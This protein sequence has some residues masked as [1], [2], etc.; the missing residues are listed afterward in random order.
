MIRFNP[1][2]PFQV[3]ATSRTQHLEREVGVSTLTGPLKSVQRARHSKSRKSSPISILT[4]S[5]KSVQLER[6]A[7]IG[8]K[9][10]VSILTG[11][12]KSVQP[13]SLRAAK[14]KKPK[15]QSSLPLSSQFN[16]SLLVS[17]DNG[18]MF[19]PSSTSEELMYQW[20]H[21]YN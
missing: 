19:Q 4:G 18:S 12:L 3:D 15:F 1:H 17:F 16:P 10:K 5:L 21:Q 13:A 11:S 8:K 9:I 2:Q 20:D 6:R 7:R 14:E